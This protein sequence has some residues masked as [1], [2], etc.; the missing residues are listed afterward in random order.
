MIEKCF[1]KRFFI[2]SLKSNIFPKKFSDKTD[3]DLI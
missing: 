2:N 1:E 3:N